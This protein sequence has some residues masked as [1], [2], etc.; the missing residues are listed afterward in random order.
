MKLSRRGVLKLSCG[1]SV[2]SALASAGLVR[3]DTAHGS[4]WIRTAF[5]QKTLKDA[6]KALGA[7]EATESTSVSILAP[8]IAE[9]S[10]AVPVTV[11]SSLENIQSIALLIEKNPNMLAALYRFSP[12]TPGEV[13]SRVKMAQTSNVYALVESG[14]KFHLAKKEIKVTLGGCGG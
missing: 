14:G 11:V 9:N 1:A 5:S 4:D 2:M 10:A 3:S 13:Q 8:D 7:S 6:L 12:G